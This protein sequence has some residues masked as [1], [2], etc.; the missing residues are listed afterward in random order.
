VDSEETALQELEDCCDETI[1]DS[2]WI[3]NLRLQYLHVRHLRSA[4]GAPAL[5]VAGSGREVCTT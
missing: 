4:R 2:I 1:D 3:E 5:R